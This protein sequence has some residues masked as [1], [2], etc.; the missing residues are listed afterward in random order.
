MLPAF[1][2][3]ERDVDGFKKCPQNPIYKKYILEPPKYPRWIINN[4]NKLNYISQ[5]F[6]N[7]FHLTFLKK[8]AFVQLLLQ[9]SFQP[10]YNKL[11]LGSNQYY[12]I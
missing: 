12:Q 7:H 4:N 2:E 10:T 3:R 5:C 9:L 8:E 11:L 6:V 1:K